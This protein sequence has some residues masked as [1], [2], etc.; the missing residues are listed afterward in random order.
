MIGAKSPITVTIGADHKDK[1]GN[2]IA[3]SVAIQAPDPPKCTRFKCLWKFFLDT[4]LCGAISKYH[5]ERVVYAEKNRCKKIS[6]KY[7][8]GEDAPKTIKQAVWAIF[9]LRLLSLRR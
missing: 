3:R 8:T 5:R 9:K 7:R 2:L 4:L 6:M 1:D